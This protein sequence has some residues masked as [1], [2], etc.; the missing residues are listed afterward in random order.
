M[1][2][3]I[4]YDTLFKQLTVQLRDGAI[5]CRVTRHLQTLASSQLNSVA[6]HVIVDVNIFLGDRN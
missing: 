3:R 4:S 6:L 5:R 1:E 2:Y